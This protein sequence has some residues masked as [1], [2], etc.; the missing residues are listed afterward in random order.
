[1]ADLLV[2]LHDAQRGEGPRAS[3]R[4]KFVVSKV[5]KLLDE[6]SVQV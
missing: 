6:C 1:M 4:K 2:G 3:S 5:H